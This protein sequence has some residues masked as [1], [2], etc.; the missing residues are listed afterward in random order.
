M[1]NERKYTINKANF[2]TD[3][4]EFW[5]EHSEYVDRDLLTLAEQTKDIADS[6]PSISQTH[7]DWK[8]SAAKMLWNSRVI[9]SQTKY[10]LFKE[11]GLRWSTK[12][13]G[14]GWIFLLL[15]YGPYSSKELLDILINNE[16]MKQRAH[17]FRET[18]FLKIK[19]YIRSV[20]PKNTQCLQRKLYILNTWLILD[21][22]QGWIATDEK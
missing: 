14:C 17:L 12:L 1:K 8:D 19:P 6:T 4:S 22:L 18:E 15:S 21:R 16:R 13:D 9:D 3:F 5:K 2:D 11:Q 20:R 10:R 7:H